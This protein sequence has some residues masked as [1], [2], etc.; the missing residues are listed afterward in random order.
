MADIGMVVSQ[1]A[2]LPGDGLGDLLTSIA[3]IDAIEP[4]EGVEK[5]MPVPVL[6][7]DPVTP[8]D[9]PVRRLAFLQSCVMDYTGWIPR[10]L[11]DR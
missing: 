6:D 3:D 11:V 8:G 10:I 2:R 9:D 7:I 5:T 1:L 4:G